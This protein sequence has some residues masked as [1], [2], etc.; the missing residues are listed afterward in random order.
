MLKH[1]LILFEFLKI[2]WEVAVSSGLVGEKH[3][4][5]IGPILSEHIL[6]QIHSEALRT[7][8]SC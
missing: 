5:T 3:L 7:H 4:Q 8:D 2:H 6:Y 1:I